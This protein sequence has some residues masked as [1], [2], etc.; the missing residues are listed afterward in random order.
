MDAEQQDQQRRHQR[1]ATHAGHPDKQA[2]A[3][4]GG[5]IERINH[6]WGILG[7][8]RRSGNMT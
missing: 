6:V 4:S 3:K 1:A 5:D 2:D 8:S 7:L